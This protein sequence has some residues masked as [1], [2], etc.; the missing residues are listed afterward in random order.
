[1]QKRVNYEMV[2]PLNFLAGA[3]G[4]GP[5]I[6]IHDAIHGQYVAICLDVDLN[7][8]LGW[9]EIIRDGEVFHRQHREVEIVVVGVVFH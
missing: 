8:L 7:R 1:M 2:N 3:R 5:P 6:W 9:S 4:F